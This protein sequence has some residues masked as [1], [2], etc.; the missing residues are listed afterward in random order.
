MG[1][2]YAYIGPAMGG[3]HLLKHAPVVASILFL[4]FV[5]LISYL[6]PSLSRW[7]RSG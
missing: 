5:D 3:I 4:L 1:Q 6:Y 7:N 2:F